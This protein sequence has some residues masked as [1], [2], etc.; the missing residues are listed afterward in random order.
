MPQP[1]LGEIRLFACP[2]VPAGW[3]P[4]DGRRLEISRYR[5]LFALLGESFGRTRTTFNLPDLRG[6]AMLGAGGS[7]HPLGQAGGQERVALKRRF[8]THS[9]GL[10]GINTPGTTN[11]P[12]GTLLANVNDG[13]NKVFAYIDKDSVTTVETLEGDALSNA[14][15]YAEHENMQPSLALNFCI[16]LTGI[17]PVAE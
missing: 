14:G 3:A 15:G 1:Y 9:H 7:V 2:N 17:S 13:G 11:S 4:C 16:A 12:D 6:R 8:F 10:R 5:D